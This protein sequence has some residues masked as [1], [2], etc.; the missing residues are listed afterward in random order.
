MT[1]AVDTNIL[2]D[3]LNKDKRYFESSRRLLIT[4]LKKGSLIINEVV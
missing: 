1:T 2:I 4:A 3:V